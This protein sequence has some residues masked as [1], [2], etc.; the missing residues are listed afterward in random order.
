MIDS[1]FSPTDFDINRIKSPKTDL[2]SEQLL[3]IV[4]KE[5]ELDQNNGN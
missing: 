2:A 1:P 4:I 5:I 3:N